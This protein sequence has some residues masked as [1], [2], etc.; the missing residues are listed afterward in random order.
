MRAS[1]KKNFN[2]NFIKQF[3]Y[4]NT[5]ADSIVGGNL[6]VAIVTPGIRIRSLHA[7]PNHRVPTHPRL[8]GPRPSP[9]RRVVTAQRTQ[10]LV[11]EEQE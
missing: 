5:D 3:T 11:D 9:T 4:Q 6:F 1:Y 2:L 7:I 10:P 8:T